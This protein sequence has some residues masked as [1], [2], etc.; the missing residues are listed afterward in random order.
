MS[1]EC[2]G[3]LILA[4]VRVDAFQVGEHDVSRQ[5]V[6]VLVASVLDDGIRDGVLVLADKVASAT[7]AGLFIRHARSPR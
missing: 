3:R 5:G 6:T 4:L 2:S 7:W 1:S